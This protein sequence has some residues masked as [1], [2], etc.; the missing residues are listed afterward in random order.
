MK[1]NLFSTVASALLVVLIAQSAYG[2]TISP[3]E[4]FLLLQLDIFL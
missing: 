1:L 3:S 2:I 4:F